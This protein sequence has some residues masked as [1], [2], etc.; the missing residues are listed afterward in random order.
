MRN[1]RKFLGLAGDAVSFA[2]GAGRRLARRPYLTRI[3]HGHLPRMLAPQTAYLLRE[4]GEDWQ[5]S[6]LC[7]CGCGSI[8]E[9]NL[10]TDERPVWHATIEADKTLTL[11][12][13]VW[14]HVG[15]RSHFIMR[16]GRIVWC[17]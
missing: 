4:A 13:S 15:C 17:G 11:K 3:A 8:I 10:L 9:L 7:P 5:A 1:W 6:M 14:R 2:W 16:R 12:P